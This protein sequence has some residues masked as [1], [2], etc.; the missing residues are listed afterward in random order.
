MVKKRTD[1]VPRSV[2]VG[3]AAAMVAAGGGAAW[4]TL[5]AANSPTNPPPPSTTASQPSTSGLGSLSAPSREQTA[6][7]YWLKDTDRHLALVKSSVKLRT[8]NQPDAILTAA[9]DRLLA[10][11]TQAG[12]TSTIP[13]G[14]KLRDVK[15]K[16]DGVH[17]NLSQ[18]FTSGGGS[19]SMTGRVGQVLYTATSLEPSARVWISVEGKPLTILGGEGL[20]LEQPL[21]RQSFQHNFSLL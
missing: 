15:T 5:H 16:S 17:V 6:Q 4:W 9:F 7:V 10:G 11:P 20:E 12:M 8:T 14:T 3:I 1:G 2:V 13:Q 21:T 18:E 19:D